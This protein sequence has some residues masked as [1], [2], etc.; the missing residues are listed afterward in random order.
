MAGLNPAQADAIL[1]YTIKEHFSFTNDDLKGYEKVLKGYRKEPKE[2]ESKRL[3]REDLIEILTLEE[4][5]R[6]AHPA[7]D[8]TDGVMSFA[9]VIKDTFC[10][11][12]SDKRLCPFEDA[13]SEGIILKYRREIRTSKFLA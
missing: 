4:G 11:V 9:V 12:T 6:T 1:K 7:Q 2:T 5:S 3:S 13:E 8:F 10:L